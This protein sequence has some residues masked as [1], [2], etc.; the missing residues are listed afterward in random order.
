VKEGGPLPVTPIVLTANEEENLPSTLRSLSWADRILVLDSGSSDGTERIARADPRVVFDV[1]PFDELARQWRHAFEHP[2]VRTRWVLALDAD[3]VVP[4]RFV[5]ELGRDFVPGQ[6]AGGS[7]AFDYAVGG[8][9]LLGS[10]YPR[11]LRVLDRARA[12]VTQRGHRHVF[13]ADGPV[14]RFRSR[15]LHDDRKPLERFL[16]A[17]HGYALRELDRIR[18]G[19]GLRVRDRIRRLGWMAPLVFLLAWIRAG[20]PFWGKASLAYAH[21]RALYEAILALHLMR[22]G[23]AAESRSDDASSARAGR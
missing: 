2:A 13:G 14:Y 22:G 3:M 4:R 16:R 19:R 23:L 17:Q 18:G 8:S 20:G 7:V 9:K 12:T 6:Y 11:D 5:E 15:I 10:L 1:R 21:E